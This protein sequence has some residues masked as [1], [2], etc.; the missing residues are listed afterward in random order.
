VKY[1]IV[2]ANGTIASASST[3]NPSLFR[4]L[5]GGSNNF[6]IVTRFDA[7]LFTQSL[8][9]GG[10]IFQPIENKEAVFE[11]FT[12]FTVSANYDSYSA[13][14]TTFE[15]VAGVPAI[16]HNAVYTTGDVAWPPPVFKVLNEMPKLVQT[17][18]KDTISG[19]GAEM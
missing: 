16:G 4:A 19:L 9:W 6:G 7:K 10:F 1:E 17:T 12:N 15:W 11:Y 8:F 14:I 2:F 5:K 3:T 13:L 18:R